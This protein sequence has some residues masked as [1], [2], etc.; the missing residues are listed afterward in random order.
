M[1]PM[2]SSIAF[3]CDVLGMQV[4]ILLSNA[5]FEGEL[6]PLTTDPPSLVVGQAGAS[7]EYPFEAA[8][9]VAGCQL[10]MFLPGFRVRYLTR[11]HARLRAWIYG[12]MRLVQPGF[13]LKPDLEGPVAQ[14]L[15]LLNQMIVGERREALSMT[16]AKLIRDGASLDLKG[17][18]QG[19]DATADR[20]GYFFCNDLPLVVEMIRGRSE[21]KQEAKERVAELLRYSVSDQYLDARVQLVMGRQNTTPPPQQSAYPRAMAR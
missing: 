17:W 10:A 7:R 4:P 16:V 9:F 18:I 3:L 13:P 20:I 5:N 12:A 6:E 15:P 19:V 8:A 14:I 2:T 11:N 21:S 1:S